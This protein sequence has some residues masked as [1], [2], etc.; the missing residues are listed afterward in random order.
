[1]KYWIIDGKDVDITLSDRT[2]NDIFYVDVKWHSDTPVTPKEFGVRF[3]IATVDTYSVFS[4][5]MR[6]L[7]SLDRNYFPR[8][9]DARLASW[10][11]LHQLISLSG[12]NRF[13]MTLR[14]RW[15]RMWFAPILV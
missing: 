4:P 6:G 10:M 15:E 14:F 7:R 9:T 2:E 1:M 5:S 11:P 3:K 12:E 13:C 8:I